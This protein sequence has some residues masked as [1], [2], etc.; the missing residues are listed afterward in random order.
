MRAE[1]ERRGATSA[2]RGRDPHPGPEPH[3]REQADRSPVDGTTPSTCGSPCSHPTISRLV[4][5]APAGR[6]DFVDDLLV[7]SSAADR[8]SVSTDYERV[9]KQRNAL[10]RGGVRDAEDAHDARRARRRVSSRAAAELVARSVRADRSTDTADRARR[11][12]RSRASRRGSRR[13][14]KP[15]GARARWNRAGSTTSRTCCEVRSRPCAGGRPTAASRSSDRIAT[16]GVRCST[17]STRASTRRRA[18]NARSRSR[19]G[20]RAIASSRRSS[21]ADPLLLLDDV[22]SEL[23]PERSAALVVHLPGD[24]DAADHR[25]ASSRRASRPSAT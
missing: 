15:S 8:A 16:T 3:P 22:F 9:L 5:G 11:T 17:T 14:T 12:S 24:A 18:S 7:A 25:R 20:S 1:I 4:K 21:G 6:R 19:C 23:D 10:L 2:H 13:R